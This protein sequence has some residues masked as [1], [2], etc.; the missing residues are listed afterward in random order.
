MNRLHNTKNPN[1][2]DTKKVLTVCSASILRSPTAAN[3][4]HREFGYNTRSAGIVSDFALIPVDNAL[5]AWADEIVCMEEW[6][7]KELEAL[8]NIR[9]PIIVLDVPDHF[10]WMDKELQDMILE[11][12][13]TQSQET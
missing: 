9:V 1:Q 6:Q 7:R 12:Y 10:Q 8:F 4:L 11:S 2:T 5:V 13:T 3:V